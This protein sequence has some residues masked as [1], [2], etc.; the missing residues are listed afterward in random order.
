M[1]KPPQGQREAAKDVFT[2]SVALLA[3]T[4]AFVVAVF[5][6]GP[7]YSHSIGPVR[8]F[9]VSQYGSAFSDVATLFWGVV[10]AIIIFAFARA[11][12]AT[13]ITL[14]GLAIAARLF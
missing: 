8:S 14:G 7:L 1:L 2:G 11:S 13:A 5:L 9:L 6:T 12:L 10:L 3:N 4:L